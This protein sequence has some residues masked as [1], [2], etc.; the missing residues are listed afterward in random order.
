MESVYRFTREYTAGREPT[1]KQRAEHR[2][3]KECLVIELNKDKTW[4]K[5][6]YKFKQEYW[7]AVDLGGKSLSNTSAKDITYVETKGLDQQFHIVCAICDHVIDL[8]ANMITF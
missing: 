4:I 2:L 6:K 8:W 3:W 7:M 1:D 5:I